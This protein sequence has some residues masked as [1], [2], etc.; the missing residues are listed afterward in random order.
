MERFIVL[1][2]IWWWESR[3]ISTV[4]VKN[5]VRIQRLYRGSADELY[6]VAHRLRNRKTTLMY[7]VSLAIILFISV[8]F[9]LQI[10]TFKYAAAQSHGTDL[11]G[12]AVA[13]V[14]PAK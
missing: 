2:F 1:L 6:Q 3:A 4:V 7:S 12:V 9:S 8:S 13:V 11:V 14:G 5:L 10:E